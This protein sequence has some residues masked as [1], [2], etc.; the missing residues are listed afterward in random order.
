MWAQTEAT[1]LDSLHG[2]RRMREL[3]HGLESRVGMGELNAMDA[4][5]ELLAEFAT[6]LPEQDWAQLDESG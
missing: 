5:A 2:T 3:A 1:L 4:S 6:Q